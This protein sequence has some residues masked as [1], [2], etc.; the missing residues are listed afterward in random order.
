MERKIP[1]NFSLYDS[2][3]GSTF[4]EEQYYIIL[5]DAIGS[6][7][8]SQELYSDEVIKYFI[9][10]L[11]FEEEVRLNSMRE[12]GKIQNRQSLLVNKDKRMIITTRLRQSKGD[13]IIS[14]DIYYDVSNGGIEEQLNF[15]ELDKFKKLPTKSNIQIVKSDMSHLDTEEYELSVPECDLELNY[16]KDFLKLHNTMVERLNTIGDKGIVLFHGDP[17]TGKTTYIKMLIHLIKNKEV[18][19]IPPSMAEALS[20]PSIITFLMEHKNSILLIEDAE[21][22][23]KSRDDKGSQVAVSNILNLTD[24]ILGDCLNVQ[25]IATFNMP[26]EKIDSALLRK[27][28]LIAEHKFEK[29]SKEDTN[30]LLKKLGKDMVSNEGLTLADI[31]NIDTDSNRISVEPKKIGF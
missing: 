26:R 23:V 9:K 28:R 25:V 12:V 1:L 7:H 29:L 27:G 22:V 21:K 24:G 8:S 31:Y 13:G 14:I 4:P 18:L 6:S 2:I 19:F 16:G 30:I 3:Y 11:G 5:F 10:S 17:G 20:D 15:I